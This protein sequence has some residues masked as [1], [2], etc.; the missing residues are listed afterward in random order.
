MIASFMRESFLKTAGEDAISVLPGAPNGGNGD[1][2]TPCVDG[3]AWT[4]VLNEPQIEQK[5]GLLGDDV[6]DRE[7]GDMA[8]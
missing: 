2:G 8:L 7:E 3:E 4:V 6:S 5:L 1:I